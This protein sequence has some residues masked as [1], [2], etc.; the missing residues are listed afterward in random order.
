MDVYKYFYLKVHSFTY[1]LTSCFRACLNLKMSCDGRKKMSS[2][3][4]HV[5]YFSFQSWFVKM[6]SDPTIMYIYMWSILFVKPTNRKLLLIFPDV[7]PTN[8]KLLLIFPD[9]FPYL[10]PKTNLDQLDQLD[11]LELLVLFGPFRFFDFLTFWTFLT[12]CTL[13][14]LTLFLPFLFILLEKQTNKLTN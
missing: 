8:R 6:E 13:W 12:F 3:N 14:T 1:L 11:Q 9:D 4:K 10:H 7:K 5:Y 2:A